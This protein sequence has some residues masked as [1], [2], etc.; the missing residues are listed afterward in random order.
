ML[1][2]EHVVD[3]V[4]RFLKRNGIRIVDVCPTRRQGEDIRALTR[5]RGTKITIEAKGETSSDPKGKRYGKQFNSGQVRDHVAKAIYSSATHITAGTLTGIA[6]PKNDAHIEYVRRV[7][8]VLKQLRIE[9][10]WVD[11]KRNVEVQGHW[12][13]W[14]DRFGSPRTN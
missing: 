4:C 5:D 2:E 9:V 12:R 14:T 1:Y 8:P 3:C 13:I 7:L 10:F 11:A 6:L